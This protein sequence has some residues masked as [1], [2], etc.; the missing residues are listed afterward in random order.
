MLLLDVD[1]QKKDGSGEEKKE[2][3][4]AEK[5]KKISHENVQSLSPS[6]RAEDPRS[7]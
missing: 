5:E 3:K 2:K 4:S 6:S 1:D 7:S